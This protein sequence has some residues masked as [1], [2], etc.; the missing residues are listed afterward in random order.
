MVTLQDI[1]EE[2]EH[3]Y[4]G[5]R[6][7]PGHERMDT[8]IRIDEADSE[9]YS[10]RFPHRPTTDP[11]RIGMYWQLKCFKAL[12]HPRWREFVMSLPADLVADEDKDQLDLNN[13]SVEIRTGVGIIHLK[14]YIIYLMMSPRQKALW[15]LTAC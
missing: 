10:I 9:P 2:L 5:T 14:T 11:G 13:Y 1:V 6:L 3:R 12:R 15:R 8:V 7:A 4:L